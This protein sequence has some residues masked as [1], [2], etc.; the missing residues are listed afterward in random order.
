MSSGLVLP[1]AVARLRASCEV[2]KLE[3][4]IYQNQTDAE[5]FVK[6]YI[7]SCRNFLTLCMVMRAVGEDDIMIMGNMLPV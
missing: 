7:D 3:N 1:S 6:T 5:V 4:G 2:S